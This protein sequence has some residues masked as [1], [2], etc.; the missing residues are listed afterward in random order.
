MALWLGR[1]TAFM[2]ILTLGKPVFRRLPGSAFQR[3]G[4]GFLVKVH[5]V[6]G[7]ATLALG[8]AHGLLAYGPE[9]LFSGHILWLMIFLAT[10]TGYM[11]ERRV[12]GGILRV[13][14]LA[15][16]GVGGMFLMHYFLRHL[17]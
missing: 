17:I 12:K 8:I 13:H 14:R 7:A 10:F 9:F 1:L 11:M 16:L 3:R 4:L 15:S 5:P 6:T 2:L